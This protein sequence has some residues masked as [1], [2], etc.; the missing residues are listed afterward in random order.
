MTLIHFNVSP[1]T[2]HPEKLVMV[3]LILDH[4]LRHTFG[5]RNSSTNG[6]NTGYI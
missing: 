3:F 5:N 6:N 4:Q 2:R 1:E